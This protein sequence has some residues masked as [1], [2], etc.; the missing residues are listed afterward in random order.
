MPTKCQYDYIHQACNT[1]TLL[2]KHGRRS[3]NRV[4]AREMEGDCV[5]EVQRVPIDDT[6]LNPLSHGSVH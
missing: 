2:L 5:G 3:P 4:D 6:N 1:E